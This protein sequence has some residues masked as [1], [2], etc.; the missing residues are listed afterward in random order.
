MRNSTFLYIGAWNFYNRVLW[1]VE[2]DGVIFALFSPYFLKWGKI[3]QARNFWWVRL[4]LMKL[5][6]LKSALKYGS[7]SI[8]IP[9]FR[10]SVTIE[11]GRSLLQFVTTNCLTCKHFRSLLN[12]TEHF[13]MLLISYKFLN[14]EL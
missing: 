6:Y 14:H 7:I 5:I 11:P 3:S 12:A 2:S 1:Y 9:F 10:V 13:L 8:K 4:I